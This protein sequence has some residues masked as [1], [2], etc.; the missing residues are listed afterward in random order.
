[1][2]DAFAKVRSRA[3][4]VKRE[5]SLD[6]SPR[7]READTSATA[8]LG[9]FLRM[10]QVSTCDVATFFKLSPRNA[11]GLCVRWVEEG[12]L[13][14]TDPSKKKHRRYGLAEPY[15]TPAGRQTGPLPL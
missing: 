4:Q 13:V 1:M 9:L 3:E 7:L 6:Q 8:A 5:G 2:A 11:S 14:V 10:K 15:E 12:F